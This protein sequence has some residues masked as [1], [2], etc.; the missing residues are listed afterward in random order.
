MCF[1]ARMNSQRAFTM[2]EML[3][4]LAV[5]VILALLAVPSMQ[6][7][8]MRK[9]V[10]EA[11]KLA[12]LAKAGVQAG[13]LLT[14]DVPADNAAAGVPAPDK[15]VS[16]LVK[17]LKVDRGAITLTFG[18]NANTALHDKHVTLLPAV[19]PDEARVP[20]AWLCHAAAVPKNMQVKGE[21]RTDIQDGWLPIECRGPAP[22]K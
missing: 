15:M 22:M 10:K 17:E 11:L 1:N 2:I 21:D 20:I 16:A 7:S 18:N 3:A 9:Q 14:G 8:V 5:I 13:Y 19:V 6:E 12:D 4:V